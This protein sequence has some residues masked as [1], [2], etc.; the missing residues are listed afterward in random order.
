M[1][2]QNN[3][4]VLSDKGRQQM[5]PH[6]QRKTEFKSNLDPTPRELCGLFWL[7]VR[8]PGLAL[9]PRQPMKVSL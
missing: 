3:L 7:R 1:N 6:S 8:A 2:K 5:P 4:I 9:L